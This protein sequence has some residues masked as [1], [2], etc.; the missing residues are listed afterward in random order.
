MIGFLLRSSSLSLLFV[1]FLLE[2]VLSVPH[3]ALHSTPC[4]PFPVSVCFVPLSPIVLST[5]TLLAARFCPLPCSMYPS[6]RRACMY[7]YK[8]IEAYPHSM[9]PRQVR[10][11][12][13]D[14]AHFRRSLS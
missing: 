7:V 6:V 3:P 12:M 11:L 13:N 5:I 2:F 4:Y 10:E 9:R 14:G 8:Y 1:R